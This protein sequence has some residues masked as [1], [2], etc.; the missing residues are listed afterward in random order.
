MFLPSDREVAFLKKYV[1]HTATAY[2]LRE[3]KKKIFLFWGKY[4]YFE[5]LFDSRKIWF[6][7]FFLNMVTQLE[8]F[9]NGT[10]GTNSSVA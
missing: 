8:I 1:I 2:L 9:I 4:I 6:L 3:K 5:P 7:V 10:V